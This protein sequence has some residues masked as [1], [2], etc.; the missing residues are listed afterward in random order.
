MA[1]VDCGEIL[2][3]MAPC[4]CGLPLR[5]KYYSN[6]MMNDSGILNPKI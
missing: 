1:R 3:E 6:E 5:K 4:D 2:N